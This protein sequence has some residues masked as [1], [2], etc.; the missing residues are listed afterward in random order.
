M[1]VGEDEFI[2]REAK[3]ALIEGPNGLSCPGPI[4]SEVG[5]IIY[6]GKYEFG[7]LGVWL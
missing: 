7:C 2:A 5:Q 3:V 1:E 4:T 6:R